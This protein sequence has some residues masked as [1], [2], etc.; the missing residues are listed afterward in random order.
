[1]HKSQYNILNNI[2]SFIL[3]AATLSFPSCAPEY[4]GPNPVNYEDFVEEQDKHPAFSPDGEYIAYYHYSSQLPEP[5]DYPSGLYIVDKNGNNRTL[6]LEG[7]HYNP[8]WSPDGE[9]LVFS[10]GGLIQ[11]CK[12]NGAEVTIFSG[13]NY[14]D[15]PQFYFPD[16]SS[17]GSYIIFGKPFAPDGGL[18]FTT[19][20]FS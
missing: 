8:A 5:V 1:M 12:I 7:Y 19:S 18:Y 15:N 20:D 14:L 13:L 4:G 2:L 6:V 11:K 9:W 10:S 16:W 3:L 17:N